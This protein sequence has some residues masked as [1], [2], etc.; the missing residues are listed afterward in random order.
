M[1]ESLKFFDDEANRMLRFLSHPLY[2]YQKIKR[3]KHALEMLRLKRSDNVIEIG[4][5]V[6][7]QIPEIANRCKSYVGIDFSKEAIKFCK[8]IKNVKLKIADAYKIPFKNNSFDVVIMIDVFHNL[9][10]SKKV[11]NEA[12][13]VLK[14]NGKI[15][16][17]V[18]NWYSFYGLT[19]IIFEKILKWKYKFLSP[20]NNWYTF[21]SVISLMKSEGFSIKEIRSSFFLPHFFTGKS[22][23]IP[24]LEIIPRI[25][26]NFET[27]LSKYFKYF[28]YHIILCCLKNN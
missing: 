18:A 4:C 2:R 26:D 22:Y 14:K 3:Y 25:Y 16:I 7:Y 12:K 15:V 6:G 24:P 28:G 19:R 21:S 5:G 20:I 1:N 11:L 23:L 10:N 13:R 9:K 17:S 8:K 27:F